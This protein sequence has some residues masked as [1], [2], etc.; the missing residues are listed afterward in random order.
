MAKS[1]DMV[2]VPAGE[3]EGWGEWIRVARLRIAAERGLRHRPMSKDARAEFLA[4]LASGLAVDIAA[5]VAGVASS[6]VYRLRG[7]DDGFAQ[8][9]MDAL[10]ASTGPL[11][12]RLE[13]IGMAQTDMAAVQ[14]LKA[15]LAGRSRA[16]Y[17]NA[18]PAPRTATATAT[19][20]DGSR[21]TVHIGS[22]G[23]D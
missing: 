11:E 14:A 2:A 7:R 15:L 17:G 4:G 20:P 18:P 12:R 5:S 1:T 22:P 8:E 23:A 6:T 21:F 9:W 10:D 13:H 19:A 3:V 16:R